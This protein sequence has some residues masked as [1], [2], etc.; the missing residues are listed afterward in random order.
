MAEFRST[1]PSLN[2]T[3]KVNGCNRYFSF[4]A[5]GRPYTYGYLYVHNRDEIEALKKHPQFG[6]V[7]TLYE[8]K[9]EEKKVDKKVYAHTY[10]NIKKSQE[11]K[12]ILVRDHNVDAS[13]LNSKASIKLV[14][15]ELRIAFPDFN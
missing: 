13:K 9:Q 5:K 1:I 3:M 12:E 2:V 14:A 15:E 4:T 7:I 6:S 10:P 11:V 8:D